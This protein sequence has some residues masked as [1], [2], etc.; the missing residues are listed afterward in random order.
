LEYF[1]TSTSRL[2]QFSETSVSRSATGDSRVPVIK[3]KKFY[4]RVVMMLMF[5]V[6]KKNKVQIYRWEWQCIERLRFFYSWLQP[7]KHMAQ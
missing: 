5:S 6:R 4:F 3:Y 7:A 1:K 2:V